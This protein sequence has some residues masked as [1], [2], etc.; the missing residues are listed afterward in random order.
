MSK[1][2]GKYLCLRNRECF[3]FSTWA[4]FAFAAAEP[5]RRAAT[6]ALIA[7]V[8]RP[9]ENSDGA[10]GHFCRTLP[11]IAAQCRA[12]VAREAATER[13]ARRPWPP[14]RHARQSAAVNNK[15]EG[16]QYLEPKGNVLLGSSGKLLTFRRQESKPR[17]VYVATGRQDR[18]CWPDEIVTRRKTYSSWLQGSWL[19]MGQT[20]CTLTS[21][22]LPNSASWL[23]SS[24]AWISWKSWRSSM[25]MWR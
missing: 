12:N 23:S 19:V 22:S 17:S 5:A 9:T 13:Q 10:C 7:L 3:P 8:V 15:T 1:Q 16:L 6:T 14:Y 2:Y 18:T 4:H 25:R 11:H 24:F 20:F 21:I